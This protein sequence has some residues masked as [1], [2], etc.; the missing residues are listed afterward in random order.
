MHIHTK[1]L[2]WVCNNY[3][4]KS[5][6]YEQRTAQRTLDLRAGGTFHVHNRVLWSMCGPRQ[7]L[8]SLLCNS[9]FARSQSLSLSLCVQAKSAVKLWAIDRDTYRRILMGS[10]IRKRKM[11]ESLLEKVSILG[12]YL[13][14]SFAA[15][16]NVYI[17]VM[18]I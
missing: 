3:A 8:A 7:S 11:Y 5:D 9:I 15:C 1:S 16:I 13:C 17:C 18:C 2:K 14:Q 12:E 10:T 6:H 4:Y